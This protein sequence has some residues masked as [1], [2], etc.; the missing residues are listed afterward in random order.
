[1]RNA[2]NVLKIIA[3]IATVLVSILAILYVLDIFSAE[4]VK[5]AIIKAIAVSGILAVASLVIVLIT[6]NKSEQ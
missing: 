1:M 4:A 6:S 3:M 2:I 5:D